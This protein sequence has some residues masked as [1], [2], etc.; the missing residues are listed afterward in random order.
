MTN[1]E[2]VVRHIL[3]VLKAMSD[4]EKDAS[5]DLI[6]VGVALSSIGTRLK[7]YSAIDAVKIMEEVAEKLRTCGD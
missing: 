7:G 6:S 2:A 3:E 4:R 1:Q 5:E